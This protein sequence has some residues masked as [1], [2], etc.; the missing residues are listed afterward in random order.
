MKR[1]L[2]IRKALFAILFFQAFTLNVFAEPAYPFPIQV[3]QP[4]GTT[5]TITM[6]GDE[7][8]S[9]AVTSDGYTLL[10]NGENGWEYAEYDAKGDLKASGILA[11][12]VGKRNTTENRLIGRLTKNMHF[13]SEQI[14]R[15][16][17]MWEEKIG[18]DKLINKGAYFNNIAPV[19]E[20]GLKSAENFS[21]T[22]TKK[23]LM[24]LIQF[25]DVHFSKTQAEFAGLM[26][27][28]GYSDNGAHGSVRDYFLE[29]SYGN[30]DLTTEVAPTIYTADHDMDYYGADETTDGY[31][32]HS[33]KA[34]EL[35]A[36]A[37]QKANAD[38]VD[39]SRYD[40]DGDGE[41]DGVY[42][43]FAGYS[44][45]AGGPDDALWSHAG[46][47]AGSPILVDGVNVR[48][49]S[50][51]NELRGN[52]DF[53]MTTIGV[54]CHE[55][56]H[57]C[58][59][60]D[61]YDTDYAESGGNYPG[62]GQWDLMSYG[63]QNGSPSGS[64]PA[65]FNPLEK[66]NFG[67]VEPVELTGSASLNMPDVTTNPVVYK[68]NTTT[69][70][71]Y[72]LLENRQQNGFNTSCPGHGLMIYRKGAAD[73]SVSGNKTHPQGFY[74]V[75]ANATAA[76]PTSDVAS[77]GTLNSAFC[78]FPG[79]G[80]KTEFTDATI[81]SA[82]SLAG[83]NTNYPLTNIAENSG[84]ISFCFNGCATVNSILNFNAIAASSTQI[85]L[86][87]LNSV[88][89]IIARNTTNTFGTPVDG[90]LYSAGSSLPGGGD[91]VFAG[92]ASSF[93]DIGLS[94]STTYYYQIWAT[95]GSYNYSVASATNASTTYNSIATFP[96]TEGFE[97]EG[98]MPDYWI[99]EY[100]LNKKDWAFQ[101]GGY[102]GSYAPLSAHTG[103]YNA[104]LFSNGWTSYTTKLVSPPLDLSLTNS[105]TLI[106]WHTQLPW[107]GRQD[108]LTVY[109]KT[110]L[111]GDWVELASYS[112]SI[113]DWTRETI[114]LPNPS[115]TYYIAFEGATAYG[116]GVCL[117]DIQV[118]EPEADFTVD[119][120][121]SCTGTME[122]NFTDASIGATS[123]AWDVD[124]DGTTDYTTQNPTHIYSS[125][126]LY[127]VK[128]TINN[129]AATITK[130]KLIL[131][132]NS[133]EPAAYSGCELTAHTN[134]NYGMG[135]S[136]FVLANIDNTTPLADVYYN[137]YTC[138]NWTTL[139]Q[140]TNYNITIATGTAYNEGVKVYIDYDGNGIFEESGEAVLTFPVGKGE[141]T[142]S[143]TTPSSVAE[144][145]KGL[146]LRVISQY[147]SVPSS[148]CNNLTYGFAEDYTVY[149]SSLIVGKSSI[150]AG[151]NWSTPATWTDN[152]VPVSTDDVIITSPG[153]VTVDIEDAVCNDLTVQDGGR[154]IIEPAKV[155]SVN[156]A[157]TNNSGTDGIL[158]Q[159]S[160]DVAT[161]T[162]A[163]I[164]GTNNVDATVER[165]MTG[166]VW[167]LV[168]PVAA[169]GSVSDFLTN[170]ENSVASKPLTTHNY[171][172]APYNES[173]D[174]WSY[175]KTNETISSLFNAGT[176]YEILRN[177][178]GTVS[179]VG[180]LTGS[181]IAVPITK[182]ATG[183][184]WNLVG[185]P[186]PC[187]LNVTTFLQNGNNASSIAESYNAIYV[188]DL[189]S[190]NGGYATINFANNGNFNL[191]SGESFFVKS[192]SETGY[193]NFATGMK[194]T[195]SNAFK[196]GVLVPEI[197]LTASAQNEKVS[198]VIKYFSGTT[199]GLDPGWDAGLF[200]NGNSS[201]S[202]YSR[203]LEDNGI[204]FMLQ[205]L[206]DNDYEN[207]VIP[208]GLV[209]ERGVEVKF[210]V[211][212]LNLPSN[213]KVYLED[214]EN[215]SYS[216]LDEPG[217]YYSIKLDNASSGIGR[218]YLHAKQNVTSVQTTEN[219]LKIIPMPQQHLIHLT[220]NIDLPA[221]VF[222]Y[223]MSGRIITTRKLNGL[224]EN[225]IPMPQVTAGFYLVH[226]RTNKSIVQGKINWTNF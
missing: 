11:H 40:N 108:E 216:R 77:Y 6:K 165:W 213:Y 65:H 37:V 148:A 215:G 91:I 90:T 122:V 170:T 202:I 18:S 139:E 157:L 35:M 56:G 76:I 119:N 151:G 167:H 120:T 219:N 67:W 4:D 25:Q 86:S 5:I 118:S 97:H 205:C 3:K 204:D 74:V 145:N 128:L 9:W 13:S 89:V 50:C 200:D 117:D 197:K 110:S 111:L 102:L 187:A 147:N 136:K 61:Y 64:R 71:E 72:F 146:R 211:E 129:G 88:N 168:S 52:S 107:D 101:T 183:N 57:I 138:T 193:I 87:W 103:T 173:N 221:Q 51:S 63:L 132:L 192:A 171:A 162:G 186:Y 47:V 96:W 7:R 43:I 1:N 42:I 179:F 222:I 29:A 33:P 210:S 189:G 80:G 44:Q 60:P 224:Y 124:N 68:Y 62:T 36:E 15:M 137:N 28:V 184:G 85:N 181:D 2:L 46:V 84:V 188:S 140:N 174:T 153:T 78:P 79:T 226:I 21:P 208:I 20:N 23:L 203:L 152:I 31:T 196:S 98:A 112:N 125:P 164:N 220:G 175:F 66:I 176:G 160:S 194:S 121:I 131:V 95:D 106:F 83:A 105:P 135:I 93:N 73:Y 185:N 16:K 48:K 199:N 69:D 17:A 198:T 177:S 143:F 53:D 19:H 141:R 159:S 39:F 92:T 12:D 116:F 207:Q 134:T 82:K 26:N 212:I 155:L 133:D 127:S 55:F 191:S 70:G 22:S 195:A 109:Y 180:E 49:Y 8:V 81:P 14:I 100:I 38:G 30:F 161:G 158:I 163:L 223:D 182:T 150:L 58:G 149:F 94:A 166:N 209:A 34:P 144:L 99:Q 41:V 104:C 113:S 115:A 24:I 45:A 218:F 130:E 10:S 32:N 156:G 27:E 123:W 59:A 206:P 217:S 142:L 172:L 54:V 114:D 126:G 190:G 154:L 178:D 214:R 225:N 201:F 169:N 75:S